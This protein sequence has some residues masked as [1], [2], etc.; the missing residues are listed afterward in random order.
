M[1]SAAGGRRRRRR[2]VVKRKEVLEYIPSFDCCDCDDC[3]DCFG[4]ESLRCDGAE[5]DPQMGDLATRTC[6]VRRQYDLVEGYVEIVVIDVDVVGSV[7]LH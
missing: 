1:R 2:R 6:P 3:C 5:V 7:R 4:V